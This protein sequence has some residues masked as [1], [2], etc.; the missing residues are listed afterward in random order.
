[1]ACRFLLSPRG[2][3]FG[4]LLDPPGRGQIDGL[5]PKG[6]KSPSVGADGG[7]KAWGDWAAV[8]VPGVMIVGLETF[9]WW[10]CDNGLP[11]EGGT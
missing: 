9:E 5:V 6:D 11:E 4:R 2:D 7:E 1:M 8:T 3:G 10:C